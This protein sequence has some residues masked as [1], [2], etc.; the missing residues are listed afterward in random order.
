MLESTTGTDGTVIAFDFGEKRIGIAVGEWLLRQAHPL[1]VIDAESNVRRFA[2]IA[3]LLA[4]WQPSALVVGQAL[5]LTGKA[6]AMTARCRRFGR[7]L[8]GRFR[9]PVIFIDERLSS[10]DAAVRLRETGQNA[11]RAKQH[12]DAVAAQLI[13]QSYFDGT[14]QPASTVVPLPPLQS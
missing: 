7:Q 5:S 10:A 12:L 6:T 11:R 13:L 9:L 1:S 4:E 3:T 2:A 14:V 8:Q